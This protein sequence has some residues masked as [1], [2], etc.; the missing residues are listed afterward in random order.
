MQRIVDALFYEEDQRVAAASADAGSGSAVKEGMRSGSNAAETSAARAR[1][2]ASSASVAASAFGVS[3][4]T[5]SLLG[6]GALVA[7]D[8]K[9][10]AAAPAAPAG[11]RGADEE[12]PFTVRRL[13][14]VIAA[15]T[16]DLP[17]ELMRIVN[18]LPPG[19]YT[20]QRLCDQ[21]NSAITGHAWGQVYGTVS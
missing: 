14:V 16:A 15:E 19:N 9:P 13:D 10:A 2:A 3:E 11:V 12:E 5:A 4:R 21:I 8:A 20:R 7:S 18:L 6:L 1:G 17:D